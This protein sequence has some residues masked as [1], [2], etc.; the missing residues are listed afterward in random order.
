LNI[1]CPNAFGGEN[2]AQPDNLKALLNAVKQ[3]PV[4]KPLFIKMPVDCEREELKEL[5]DICI[6]YDVTGIV[7]SNLTKNREHIAEKDEITHL[8]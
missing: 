6:Y 5:I 4:Q 7:I 2:F 8:H 3:R 1:S